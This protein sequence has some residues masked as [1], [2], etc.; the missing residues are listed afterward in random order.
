[1]FFATG[2][3]P[4]NRLPTTA[5]ITNVWDGNLVTYSSSYDSYYVGWRAFDFSPEELAWVTESKYV[6]GVANGTT[7]INGIFGEYITL[8]LP[9]R[10]YITSY[11]I[12]TRVYE[13]N[14]PS[15]WY[16]LGWNS[17]T[18]YETIHHQDTAL[19][20]S[21]WES[22]S[23]NQTYTV[24]PSNKFIRFVLV[25]TNV[26]ASSTHLGIIEFSFL[27]NV[28]SSG[29]GCITMG[30]HCVNKMIYQ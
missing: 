28:E 29:E 2:S 17:E 20:D 5:A 6:D 3:R 1:M 8:T 9:T 15:K 27:G 26:T 18:A 7:S 4:Q 24:S 11:T 25:V 16:L 12:V 30:D 10:Y 21:D 23:L 13:G 19:S 14:K 22:S